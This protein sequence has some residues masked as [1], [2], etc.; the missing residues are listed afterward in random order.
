[1]K[2]KAMEKEYRKIPNGLIEKLWN[3][4]LNLSG[5]DYCV[6]WRIY[7]LCIWGDRVSWKHISQKKIAEQT[8]IGDKSMVSRSLKKL[9]SLGLI[10]KRI[11]G[12]IM[13]YKPVVAPESTGVLHS[14]QGVAP[15]STEVATQS[16]PVDSTA[17]PYIEKKKKEKKEKKQGEV[18]NRIPR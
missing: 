5:V 16:T 6:Y 11:E 12:G 17:P 8:G 3:Y 18:L 13:M 4:K 9:L 14:Q 15:E 2:E 1:M 7:S 10:E